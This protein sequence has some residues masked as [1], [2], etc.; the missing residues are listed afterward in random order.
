MLW[1]LGVRNA[2]FVCRS[3]FQP[4]TM[5]ELESIVAECHKNGQSL[6]VVGSALSPNGISFNEDGMLSMAL[7]DKIISVDKESMQVR[8][9]NRILATGST[10]DW[11]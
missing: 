8:F 4:E 9:A 10:V 7:L 3:F 5:T 6:R 11:T 2:E 1:E